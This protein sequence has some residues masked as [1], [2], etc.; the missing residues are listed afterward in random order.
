MAGA[1]LYA[2]VL[3]GKFDNHEVARKI[4]LETDMVLYWAIQEALSWVW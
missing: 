1:L 4:H 3:D 2:A